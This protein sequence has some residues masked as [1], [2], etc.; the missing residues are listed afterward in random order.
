MP[1][2]EKLADRNVTT[3]ELAL[4]LGITGRRVQ[5]LT[6]DGVLTTVS[7]GKFVLSDAVQAYIGSISRGGL[8]KEEAEEAKKIERVKA[9]AEATLKTSKAKIAQAEAKELSGQMHRSEDV[10]AM[11]SELIYTVRG[12]LMALPV[13]LIA[14]IGGGGLSDPA[15]VAEYMR[16]EVNQIAEEIAMFRY[17]P[18]KYEARVRERKAWAEKLAGDDDE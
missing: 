7:R 11:T 2:K 3:T 8:T 12:A 15:E 14:E 10:A 5:Q 13:W 9:K 16:G 18:A 6:Q 4:I 17:D 1:T